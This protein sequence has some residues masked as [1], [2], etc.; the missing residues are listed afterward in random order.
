MIRSWLKEQEKLWVVHFYSEMSSLKS[1]D[2]PERLPHGK[3]QKAS[4]GVA[5]SDLV[6]QKK[7]EGQII[8]NFWLFLK[9]LVWH[10][11]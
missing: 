4:V 3:Y 11:Y 6:T 2:P 7:Y 8:L 9:G 10:V 5:L 1:I